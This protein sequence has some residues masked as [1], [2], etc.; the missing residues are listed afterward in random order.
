MTLLAS[1]TEVWRD[2]LIDIRKKESLK[3]RCA[4][5]LFS[6]SN[7]DPCGCSNG[8]VKVFFSVGSPF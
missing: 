8:K 4:L 5:P 7:K 2:L 1:Y 6:G 3:R